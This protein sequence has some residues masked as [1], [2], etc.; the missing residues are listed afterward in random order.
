MARVLEQ[1]IF[2]KKKGYLTIQ[3]ESELTMLEQ[4][5]SDR[6]DGLEMERL[7][8][9]QGEKAMALDNQIALLRKILLTGNSLER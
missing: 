3:E 5:L 1:V 8:N 6:L 2:L 4:I 9:P 7:D